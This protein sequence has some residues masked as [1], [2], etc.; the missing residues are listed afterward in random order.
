MVAL[1]NV[2]DVAAMP[3]IFEPFGLAAVEALACGTPVI[4]GDVGGFSRIVNK[5]IGCLLKPGDYKTLA[6][7]VTAFI[8]DE[9]KGKVGH[10]AVDYVRKN[11][12]WNKTVGNI[13]KTYE[14]VLSSNNK[15]SDNGS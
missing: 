6:E 13:E 9:F 8:R 3:S 7:K 5:E 10:K 2:A 1:F 11:F 14:Q 4:A 12:S 15:E